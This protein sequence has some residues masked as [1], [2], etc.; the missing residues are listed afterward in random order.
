MELLVDVIR[1]PR[2]GSLRILALATMLALV[3][4][5]CGQD[6]STVAPDS[7][8]ELEFDHFEVSAGD[9]QRYPAGT[10]IVARNGVAIHGDLVIDGSTPGDFRVVC[11]AGTLAVSGRSASRPSRRR[12]REGFARLLAVS[13]VT[14]SRRP[15]A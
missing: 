5:S 6:S 7:T 3:A 1:H 2:L 14:A 13:T 8:G 12:S 9:E 15:R 11:E 10:T 4:G